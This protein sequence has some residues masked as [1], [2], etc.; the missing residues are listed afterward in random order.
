MHV[1]LVDD[2]SRTR[3]TLRRILQRLGFVDSTIAEAVDGADALEQLAQT[4]EEESPRL[5][6]TDCQ[7]PRMDGIR[8]TKA[9]RAAGISIPILM[10]SGVDDDAIIRAAT[11]AGVS[12]FLHKPLQLELFDQALRDL[13]GAMPSAA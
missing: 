4:C 12:H 10:I 7:M 6:V 3:L 11:T 9:L 8:L 13:L 2:D 5:I 1:L